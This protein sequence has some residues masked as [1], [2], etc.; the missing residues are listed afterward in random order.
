MGWGADLIAG[1][2]QWVNHLTSC[3]G[4]VGLAPFV[5][6]NLGSKTFSPA[7]IVYANEVIEQVRRLAQGFVM[8]DVTLALNE[9]AEVGPGGSFLISDLTL[10]L[11]R[12]A[13]YRSDILPNLTL[14]EWQDRGFPR[15]DEV[16]RRHTRQLLEGLS[17]PEDRAELIARGQAFIGA[18]EH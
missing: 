3:L 13:Y 2:H 12:Q 18:L 9:I 15:A 1:G 4:K 7:I 17:A 11:F 14:E 16:L 5:G 6:D 8:N 10:K